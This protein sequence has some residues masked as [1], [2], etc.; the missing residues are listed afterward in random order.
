MAFAPMKY[1]KYGKYLTALLAS[2]L[3]FAALAQDLPVVRV[4][5]TIPAEEAKYW[6]MRRPE[7]FP[8]LGKTYRIEWTQFQ[9]TAP[10]VQA[11]I[12]NA[13][14]CSSQAPLSLG[15]GAING[16]LSAYIVAQ[17]VGESPSSFSVYWGVP[18]SSPITKIADLK[19]KTVG[20]NVYGSGVYGQ[21][22]MILK[23]HG[24]DPAHDIKLVE[25][26]FPGSEAAIRGGRVDAGVFV[27]PFAARAEA[28]GGIRKLFSL[29]DL[30]PNTVHIVEVCKKDFAD[31]HPELVKAY[32]RDLTKAMKMATDQRAVTLKIVSEVTRAPVEAL[33]P[34]LMKPNDF[35]R[36][37]GAHPD[38]AAIQT[39]L[40]Q[41]T[42]LGLLSRPLKVSSFRRDDLV[43][44]LQ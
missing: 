2:S 37:P 41:Y 23:K 35:A 30:M 16:N 38:F 19:G 39:M 34:Y 44:P 32:V 15:Q 43:A 33:D 11:M 6:M 5:W 3:A 31:K 14:D 40:D 10:M 36:N 29:Q 17:H 7:A 13:L 25:T 12:S 28:K 20:V 24:L 26:G 8:D 22:A 18:E 4:G 21:M 42:Q 27:Q 1:L 9:G